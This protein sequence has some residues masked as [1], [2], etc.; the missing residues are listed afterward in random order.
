M[1]NFR[2]R[3]NKQSFTWLC[4]LRK[5]THPITLHSG[6]FQFSINT[7]VNTHL[8]VRCGSLNGFRVTFAPKDTILTQKKGQILK[9]NKTN[10]GFSYL[11]LIFCHYFNATYSFNTPRRFAESMYSINWSTTMATEAR[12]ALSLTRVANNVI[13]LILSIFW[14]I[15]EGF[16]R[17][18][19]DIRRIEA[20]TFHNMR[21]CLNFVDFLTV[22]STMLD[23]K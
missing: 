7:Y 16:W 18:I 10:E 3:E 4:F 2:T 6:S 19:F 17:I 15:I 20:L 5:R 1:K 13:T 21:K 9:T 11:T 8:Y 22:I 23:D 14:A 12:R